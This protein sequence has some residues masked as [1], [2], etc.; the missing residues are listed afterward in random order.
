MPRLDYNIRLVHIKIFVFYRNLPKAIWISIIMV[1]VVYF[2]TNVAYFTT[3][4][5]P[6]IMGGAAVAVVSVVMVTV[7]YMLPW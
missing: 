5:R 2:L 3:V 1:T 7:V 4:S 6:E